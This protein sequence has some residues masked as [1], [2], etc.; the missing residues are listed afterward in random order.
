MDTVLVTGTLPSKF[1]SVVSV[2]KLN[3]QI[4]THPTYLIILGQNN[5][6][7][8]NLPAQKQYLSQQNG[9]IMIETLSV[10]QNPYF[11][12]SSIRCSGIIAL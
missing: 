9:N 11:L 6:K 12:K 1:S 7:S 2:G 4:N 10:R 3:T 5:K 8:L